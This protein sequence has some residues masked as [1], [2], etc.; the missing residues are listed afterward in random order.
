MSQIQ[1][2]VC[3]IDDDKIYQFTAKKMLEATGM[4]KDIRSFYDG[5]EAIAFFSGEN[6]K[7]PENLPDVI[8]LDI[9]MPIMNGW[10]FLE[11]Y[12]KI[13]NHFP[14]SMALYVVSSSVDDADIRRSRQYNS[15][16]DYIVKPITRMRYQELLEGI[17]SVS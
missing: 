10:E 5:S 13:R 1:H 8:F 17:G 6:S 14:K 16:T 2:T 9:N 7:N 15:V 3:L 12:E 4:A 11:E